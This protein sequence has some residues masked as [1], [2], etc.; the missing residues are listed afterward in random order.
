VKARLAQ[1]EVGI[2]RV[3]AD[4]QCVVGVAGLRVEGA[5]EIGHGG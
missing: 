3:A 5:H 4:Q 1:L 2:G